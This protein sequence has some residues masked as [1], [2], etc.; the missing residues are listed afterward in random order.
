MLKFAGAAE[1][2][3]QQETNNLLTN[4]SFYRS[5]SLSYPQAK[6]YTN[7]SMQC[8]NSEVGMWPNTSYLGLKIPPVLTGTRKKNVGG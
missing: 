2:V 3:K 6:L 5:E 4:I 1:A 7:L 8:L